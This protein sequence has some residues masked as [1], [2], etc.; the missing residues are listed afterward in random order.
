MLL[1]VCPPRSNK[2]S[3]LPPGGTCL[4]SFRAYRDALRLPIVSERGG[5]ALFVLSARHRTR[6][7]MNR[8]KQRS[9][10]T[11]PMSFSLRFTFVVI[12]TTLTSCQSDSVRLRNPQTGQV[13]QCGLFGQ[14]SSQTAAAT[15]EQ[16][17][18]DYQSPSFV[19]STRFGFLV[20]LDV[21]AA[22]GR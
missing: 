7:E 17:L 13:A 16:C 18:G 5:G 21:G 6:N 4:R 12:F 22:I 20:Q 15:R 3:L 19:R 2:R 1:R 8:Q 14:K 10:R 9:S 11:S